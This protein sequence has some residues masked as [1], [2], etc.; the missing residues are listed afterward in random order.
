MA[1]F[2]H[3]GHMNDKH[4]YQPT[5][6]RPGDLQSYVSYIE[7]GPDTPSHKQ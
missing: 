5:H 3:M 7:D 2:G 6:R 1:V 4:G